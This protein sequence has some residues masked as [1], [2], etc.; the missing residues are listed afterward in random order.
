MASKNLTVTVD[1]QLLR[2]ARK[3]AIDENTSVQRLLTDAL[4]RFVD[5]GKPA[6]WPPLVGGRARTPV[7]ESARAIDEGRP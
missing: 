6:A 5:G 7:A 3:R 4:R 1:D 2:E